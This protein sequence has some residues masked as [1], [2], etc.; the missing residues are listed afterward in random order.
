MKIKLQVAGICIVIVSLVALVFV[1]VRMKNYIDVSSATEVS[2]KYHCNG[3]EIDVIVTDENDI[4]VLKEN[5]TGA[6]FPENPSCGFSL[7]ISIRFTDGDKSIVLCPA[8]D[9]C[10]FA[11]IGETGRYINIKDRKALETVLK[12]YGVI[13]PCV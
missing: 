11:R 6:S 9:T 8:R 7:D 5:L 3:A 1:L 4:K 2:I 12:K 13:F 10:S